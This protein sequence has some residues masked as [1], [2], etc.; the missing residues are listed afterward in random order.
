MTIAKLPGRNE[1]CWCG[2]GT[3]FKKCHYARD[4]QQPANFFDTVNTIQR[5]GKKGRCLHPNAGGG[6]CGA[7]AIASHTVQRNGG[8]AAIAE[9]GHV[10][11]TFLNA[12]DMQSSGGKIEPK[13]LGTKS[14]STFPGFC[15]KHDSE[16]FAAIEQK[17]LEPSREAA[18]LFFYRAIC[19][20]LVRKRHVAKTTMPVLR[21]A[22]SGRPLPYQ[23]NLQRYLT[24]YE[25]GIA[26][27]LQ[28]LERVKEK[29][30]VQL[31]ARDWSGAQFL[32]IG[33]DSVFP[34]TTTFGIQPETDWEG[35][36]LQDLADL[37]LVPEEI[38]L[39]VTSY[40]GKGCA[41][42]SWLGSADGLQRQFVD[43]FM[44]LPQAE[45]AAALVEVCFALSENT[46][47]RPSWWESLDQPDRDYLNQKILS[48]TPS[49]PAQQLGPPKI[50][51]SPAIVVENVRTS[52][53]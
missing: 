38:A 44:S 10:L 52:F 42:F 35:K 32:S 39:T 13:R 53:D 7:H 36:R 1:P 45:W 18:F 17:R 34:I 11:T 19:L 28:D 29:L 31:A 5:A 49:S 9:D 40:D 25:T 50:E 47:I 21:R 41:I 26:A 14:A 24:E 20:E 27:G 43:S 23:V 48:G 6:N 30:D 2:S 8:L 12:H 16:V 15:N 51:L 22:D 46:Q 33:F 3:K 4:A 37:S